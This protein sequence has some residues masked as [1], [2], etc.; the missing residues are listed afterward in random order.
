MLQHFPK[1]I[2][3]FSH[4]SEIAEHFLKKSGMTPPETLQ[5]AGFSHSPLV[6]RQCGYHFM[7]EAE[8]RAHSAKQ[9]VAAVALLSSG[10]A[11]TAEVARL[12][13]SSRQ[14]VQNWVQAR[15][16]DVKKARA[17]LL[18]KQWKAAW[19]KVQWR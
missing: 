2:F 5:T 6:K 7:T 16:L 18:K 19:E 3:A 1:F 13:R 10:K 17:T 8:K 4:R 12:L 14:R 15:D 9:Q 11:T